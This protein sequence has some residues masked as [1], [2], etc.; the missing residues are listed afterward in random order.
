[1]PIIQVSSPGSLLKVYEFCK[2][3][4]LLSLAQLILSLLLPLLTTTKQTNK[5]TNKQML[6]YFS[7]MLLEISLADYINFTTKFFSFKSS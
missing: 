2:K 3:I 4:I 7:K 5:Q 6:N 1:M